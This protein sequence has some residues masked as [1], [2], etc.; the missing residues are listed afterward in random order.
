MFTRLTRL[1]ELNLQDNIIS[2]LPSGVFTG[3]TGL[4]ELHLQ[5]NISELPSD[6]FTGLTGLIQLHLQDN[7]ISE[8][9]SF[10]FL[11]ELVYFKWFTERPEWVI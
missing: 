8:L 10:I 4:K 6:V 2:E 7:I 5:D 1:K 3:L 11:T 9:P